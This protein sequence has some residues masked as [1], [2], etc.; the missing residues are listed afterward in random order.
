MRLDFEQLYKSHYMKVY[1][2]AMTLTKKSDVAEELAQKVFLKAMTT[3]SK[4]QGQSSEFTWLCTIAKN[5]Y[6][7]DVKFQKRYSDDS[8]EN[9]QKS[10]VNIERAFA[11]EESA[12]RIHQI[13]HQLEEPYKEVFNLRIFSELSFKKIGLLFGKTENWACV[14]FHRARQ[15]IKERIEQS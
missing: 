1:S 9:E 3:K 8:I 10:D 14:T 12:F 15:K 2:F 5:L 7:D 6:L 11:D 4:Y 13:L